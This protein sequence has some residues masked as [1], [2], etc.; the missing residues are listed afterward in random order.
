MSPTGPLCDYVDITVHVHHMIVGSPGRY[1]Q[2][3]RAARQ[4]HQEK[5]TDAKIKAIK[6]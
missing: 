2:G 6:L 1:I 3:R 5:K 4:G